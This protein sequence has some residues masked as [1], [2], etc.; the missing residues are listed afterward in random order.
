MQSVEVA[1]VLEIPVRY[2]LDVVDTEDGRHASVSRAEVDE[3]QLG[4]ICRLWLPPRLVERIIGG[5][6][7]LDTADEILGRR[8]VS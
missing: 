3:Q 2:T 4:S 8:G 1:E 6:G 7:L 5:D